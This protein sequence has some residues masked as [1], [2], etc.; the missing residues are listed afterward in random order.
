MFPDTH[1]K[2]MNEMA[3]ATITKLEDLVPILEGLSKRIA[4]LER[5]VKALKDRPAPRPFDSE[6]LTKRLQE[7]A[8][9]LAGLVKRVTALEQPVEREP[10]KPKGVTFKL[11]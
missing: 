6:P 2:E 7:V 5:E 9:G 10:E 1:H 4:D 11:W 8:D 3:E